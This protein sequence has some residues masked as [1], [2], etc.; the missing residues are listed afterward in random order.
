MSEY[1]NLQNALGKNLGK[2]LSGT[3]A[4]LPDSGK[5]F[6]IVVAKNGDLVISAMVA[7][8]DLTPLLPLTVKENTP[9][10]FPGITSI[11]PSSG[12]GIA[13]NE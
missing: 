10:I 4:I 11:T 6:G 8:V 2:V 7:A 12:V 5:S 13:Y 9:F 1:V 3:S